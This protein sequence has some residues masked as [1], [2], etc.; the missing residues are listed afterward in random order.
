MTRPKGGRPRLS[1]T[2][3]GL[4]CRNC[5]NTERYVTC[6]SCVFCQRNRNR[7]I[8]LGSYGIH[9]EFHNWVTRTPAIEIQAIRELRIE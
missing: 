8:P 5:G 7:G 3:I 2:Y 1:E 4:A 9:L 6:K